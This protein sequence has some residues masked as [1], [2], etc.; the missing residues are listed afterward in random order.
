MEGDNGMG[1]VR[2]APNSLEKKFCGSTKSY[3]DEVYKNLAP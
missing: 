3:D 2:M 1:L